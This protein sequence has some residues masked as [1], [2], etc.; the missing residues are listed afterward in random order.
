MTQNLINA[1]A[2]LSTL[3]NDEKAILLQTLIALGSSPVSAP[4]SAPAP[5]PAPRKALPKA[6]DVTIPVTP[7]KVPRG[8]VAFTLGYGNGRGGAKLMV[9][10][11]GFTWDSSLADSTRK[12][13]WVGTTSQA[14]SIGLT[15]K[16]TT[17]SVSAEWVQR[18]RDKAQAK[19]EKKA[20]KSA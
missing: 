3:E 6:E 5:T 15:T 18:G 16:S 19:A 20:R 12:G 2:T 4:V 1:I 17:L 10:N 9:K 14:K 11:A 13:A 8:K 7:V